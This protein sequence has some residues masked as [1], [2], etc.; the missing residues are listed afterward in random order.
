M[1]KCTAQN[2]AHLRRASLIFSSM[3]LNLVVMLI[4]IFN[5]CLAT[6]TLRTQ[7]N[8]GKYATEQAPLSDCLVAE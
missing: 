3:F 4:W 2:D 5:F 1:K 8:E 6:T 7:E